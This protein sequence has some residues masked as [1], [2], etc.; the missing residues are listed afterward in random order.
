MR[1]AAFRSN[2][3]VAMVRSLARR[4]ARS[5]YRSAVFLAAPFRRRRLRRATVAASPV[6]KLSE[7]TIR[8]RLML[9][10]LG[11]VMPGLAYNAFVTM[12]VATTDQQQMRTS[13]RLIAG[14]IASAFDQLVAK[15]QVML[16]GIARA[17]AEHEGSPSD[18]AS[19]VRAFSHTTGQRIMLFDREGSSFFSTFD[20][21]LPGGVGRADPMTLAHV[22]ETRAPVVSDFLEPGRVAPHAAITVSVPV[23][24]RGEVVFALT[25]ILDVADLGGIL[26]NRGIG[27]DWIAGVYD[28]NGMTL[29][30]RPNANRFVGRYAGDRLLQ[31]MRVAPSGQLENAMSR[32]GVVVATS[33][34]RSHHGNWTAAVSIPIS[35]VDRPMHAA[36]LHT[37]LLGAFLLALSIALATWGGLLVERPMRSLQAAARALG[38]DEPFD[39]RPCGIRELD[40]VGRAFEAAATER[41]RY[42]AEIKA[43]VQRT[44]LALQAGKMGIFQI[45]LATKKV[46]W[47]EEQLD[48]FGVAPSETGEWPSF[49]ESRLHPDDREAVIAR[50]RLALKTLG[51]HEDEYRIIRPDGETRWIQV[52]RQIH[53]GP[54]GKPA[55]FS[56]LCVDITERKQSEAALVASEKF[57][58]SILDSSPDCIKVLDLAGKPVYFNARARAEYRLTA[59][60]GLTDCEWSSYCPPEHLATVDAAFEAAKRGE[61]VEFSACFPESRNGPRWWEVSY[62]PIADQDGNVTKILAVSRDV[63][64]R[65]RSEERQALLVREVTHRSKN[66]LAIVQSIALQSLSTGRDAEE[67]KELFVDRLHTLARSH[68]IVSNDLNEGAPIMDVMR[69][70]L[71]AFSDAV[72]I[73]GPNI[74]ISR[75][76]TQNLALAVHELATNAAKYGA[77]TSANGTIEIRWRLEGGGNAG[78]FRFRWRERGGPAPTAGAMSGFGSLLLDRVIAHELRAIPRADFTPEGLDYTIDA[79]LSEI[80][81]ELGP[82]DGLTV[83]LPPDEL[84]KAS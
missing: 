20:R 42:E 5:F 68:A 37:M 75:K 27:P 30:R 39:W 45:D 34:Q 23:M 78:R 36:I 63:T 28:R 83:A 22:F 77:L 16:E 50:R 65:M 41:S 70:E 53:A 10:I 60:P 74:M 56:G 17:I 25:A 72:E 18:L 73:R 6:F 13:S 52:F 62:S 79:P 46:Q 29:A 8:Q 48:I 19:T 44:K 84:R 32:E 14:E 11:L 15:N 43:A 31:G 64:E 21:F 71:E 55:T 49:F 35:S 24:R 67:A 38:R 54:D 12:S 7:V 33:Y 40:E 51:R 66:L 1:E 76:A 69:Q 57:A 26:S 4:V 9:L 82:K 61:R 3:V 2:S 59:A 47:S 58:R 80:A 81:A